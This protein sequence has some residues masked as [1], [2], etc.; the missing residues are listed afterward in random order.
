MKTGQTLR[1]D[2]QG[3]PGLLMHIYQHNFPYTPHS[4]RSGQPTWTF[5]FRGTGCAGW[6]VLSLQEQGKEKENGLWALPLPVFASLFLFL[7]FGCF[8]FL[9]CFCLVAFLLQL[10]FLEYISYLWLWQCC[11]HF[12]LRVFVLFL[13]KSYCIVQADLSF[14]STRISYESF[15]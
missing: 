1:N 5:G 2:T 15:F 7:L 3:W 9:L 12:N 11:C 6:Q 13:I 4:K 10:M 14:L 8:F